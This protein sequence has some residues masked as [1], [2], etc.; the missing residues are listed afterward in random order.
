MIV[1]GV[2]LNATFL[3]REQAVSRT[4]LRRRSPPRG[5]VDCRTLARFSGL[6][7]FETVFGGMES[8]IRP[9]VFRTRLGSYESVGT[10]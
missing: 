10:A 7:F 5:Q 6:M 4:S 9:L 1:S 8:A 2:V 3:V